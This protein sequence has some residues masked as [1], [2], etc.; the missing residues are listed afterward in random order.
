MRTTWQA[1][2]ESRAICKTAHWSR[3]SS[4]YMH[5]GSKCDVGLVPL[6]QRRCS[7]RLSQ[8]VQQLTCV[9][10][11]STRLGQVGHAPALVGEVNKC[12][13]SV[14]QAIAWPAAAR[15]HWR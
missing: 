8:G 15:G 1:V 6:V 14:T 11:T 2:C 12:G 5:I 9:R 3:V 10:V 13:P 4:R 7:A